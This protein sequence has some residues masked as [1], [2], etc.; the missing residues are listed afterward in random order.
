[1]I[2]WRFG[3]EPLGVRGA[4]SANF[5]TALDFHAPLR[6]MTPAFDVPAGPFPGAWPFTPPRGGTLNQSAF[7]G[8]CAAAAGTA[9]RAEIERRLE[10]HYA[11]IRWLQAVG[12]DMGAE[13]D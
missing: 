5:A 2:A 6:R 9:E 3:F 1:M 12:R 10:L 4:T 11:D 7:G 13:I 8:A